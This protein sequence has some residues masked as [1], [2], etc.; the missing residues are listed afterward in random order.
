MTRLRS[1]R[2]A[3]GAPGIEPRWTHSDK[4]A[5]GTAYSTSS[6]VWFTVS[7][8][9]LNEIYYPT[10]DRPQIPHRRDVRW[11][12]IAGSID[13]RGDVGRREGMSS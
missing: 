3:F 2:R 6:R 8:G 13:G 5:V 9:I 1:D 10:L 12:P 7:N 4:D 11:D